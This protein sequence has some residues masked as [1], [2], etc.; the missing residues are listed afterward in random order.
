MFKKNNVLVYAFRMAKD[1]FCF[2]EYNTRNVRL[3]H[4]SGCT[5]HCP[6]AM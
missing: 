2:V 6:Q 4:I 1:C 3:H 5:Y